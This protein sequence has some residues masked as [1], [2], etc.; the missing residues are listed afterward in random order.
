MEAVVHTQ[1]G[2]VFYQMFH[3]PCQFPD[4]LPDHP[5]ADAADSLT[6]TLRHPNLE[7]CT[8]ICVIG[9]S[10]LARFKAGMTDS[11]CWHSM[12]QVYT[13][14]SCLALLAD[15]TM[16]DHYQRTGAYILTPGTL[17]RW[18]TSIIQAGVECPPAP[19]SLGESTTHLVLFDTG[20]DPDSAEQLH[21]CANQVGLPCTI[22][23]IGLGFFQALVT[24]IILEWRLKH[25]RQVSQSTIA[26]TQRHLSN[27][28][29]VIDLIGEMNHLRTE[30]EV[31]DAIFDLFTM[32][33]SPHTQVYIPLTDGIGGLAR[34]R[35]Q[36][37]QMDMSLRNRLCA[38]Q[39][40][41]AWTES[42]QGF[43]LRISYRDEILGVLYVDGF[44]FAEYRKEYLNLALMLVKVC[45]L[46][47]K[48]A[49]MYEQ[50]HNALDELQ[51]AMEQLRK[52]RDDA[53]T[54]NRAKSE[55]LA[56]MS[57]EIRTPL[58]AIIGMTEL[59]LDT[60]LSMEQ[61]DF[62]STV[63]TSG[64][65]LLSIINDIL[66]FSKIE[67]GKLELEQQPFHLRT[68]IEES[69]DLVALKADQKY[70][71]L[72]Y[73]LDDEMPEVITGDSMRVR[74]ILFNLLSNAVKFTEQ[75]E[76]VLS[77]GTFTDTIS[78]PET[79][80]PD[81]WHDPLIQPVQPVAML[82]NDTS[83]PSPVTIH[84]SVKD[85]GIG[86]PRNLLHRL[87][88]S[89]SQV[90]ASMTRKYG[91]TGLGLAI[92]KQLARM[93]GGSIWVESQEGTGS[94]FHATFRA[95]AVRSETRQF[96]D[97]DDLTRTI[98]KPATGAHDDSPL[99]CLVNKR[100]VFF[101]EY[102]TN[103]ALLRRYMALWGIHVSGG[104]SAIELLPLLSQE[105][106][107]PFDAI[108][109]DLHE[110]N[111]QT[112]LLL[113]KVS[114]YRTHHPLAV[115]A[116]VPFTSEGK[117]LHQARFRIDMFLNRPIKPV[118]LCR[119]LLALF[120]ERGAAEE[121]GHHASF[122]EKV[123]PLHSVHAAS[124][125][126]LRILLA[127]DNAF[128]QKVALRMLQHIGYE[129]DIATNGVD[130]LAK[131]NEQVYDVVLMDVQMPQMDGLEA[132][133]SIRSREAAAYQ[134]Y[135]IAM[136]ANALQ[137]DRE[138]CLQAGMDDYVSKPV[139]VKDLVDA[140]ERA[141]SRDQHSSPARSQRG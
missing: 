99:T 27:Y 139:Q 3:L 8:D 4:H 109:L 64:H 39:D 1:P 112:N 141:Q 116:F 96:E 71:N 76:V 10:C 136:T 131:M 134:P 30:S 135:I 67:A 127:E 97:S 46:A 11:F 121:S 62:V 40:E 113:S 37:F 9:G 72:A 2:D 5:D 86:I 95:R 29:M 108:I 61:Q 122:D 66:D 26:T 90:D 35:P 14:D 81:P 49:R 63:H 33:Y 126:P 98:L 34:S 91:G 16:I 114:A 115:I 78:T 88:Q 102:Q 56:T 107:P 119:A 73:T 103:Q 7:D 100:I 15:Q 45:G 118:H 48:N 44:T 137:G 123:S 36:S 42:E 79:T 12:C 117:K 52:A 47:I 125:T 23:P 82:S 87:F 58:N 69:L 106:P 57:H 20:V 130:V 38:M 24:N 60:N 110:I 124:D 70:L 55:F 65:T 68:C 92:S 138:R 19:P 120:S 32:M 13:Q 43:I 80:I 83:E 101:S 77:V 111:N 89:F 25:E 74:Q 50:L 85:T 140:L 17:A 133:R 84:L 22:M 21:T 129:A 104:D 54:A 28:E 75:G 132:T 53:N 105:P 18:H 94:T 31:I 41:Y 93:M 128:N 51:T 6:N 59:L